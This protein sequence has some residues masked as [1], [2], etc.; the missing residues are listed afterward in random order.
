MSRYLKVKMYRECPWPP[1]SSTS[2]SP[3]AGGP[4]AYSPPISPAA[5]AAWAASRAT[6]AAPPHFNT[7]PREP[8]RQPVPRRLGFGAQ[9]HELAQPFREPAQGDAVLGASVLE[10]F[11]TAVG[12]VHLPSLALPSPSFGRSH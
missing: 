9:V 11:D 3:P 6:G 10:F 5:P 4:G 1:S 8:G 2:S 12:E 7:G